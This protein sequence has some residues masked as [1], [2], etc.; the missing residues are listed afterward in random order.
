[1]ANI[2]IWHMDNDQIR[3]LTSGISYS[4]HKSFDVWAVA[5]AYLCTFYTHCKKPEDFDSMNENAPE[6]P[7]NLNNPCPM[8]SPFQV[9]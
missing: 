1:M 3:L 7:S 6:K 4:M 8:S 9:W 2:W 5:F